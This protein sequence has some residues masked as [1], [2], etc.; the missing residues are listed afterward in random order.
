LLEV[1]KALKGDPEVNEIEE[2]FKKWQEKSLEAY[3]SQI[4]CMRKL[5]HEILQLKTVVSK[6]VHTLFI[7]III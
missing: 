3:Q 1:T 7:I 5:Q 4:L 6:T 2:E